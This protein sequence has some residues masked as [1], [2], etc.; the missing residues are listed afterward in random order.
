[1]NNGTANNTGNVVGVGNNR[2]VSADGIYVATATGTF[3][4]SMISLS[5]G[6]V[7]VKADSI[8]EYE[9]VL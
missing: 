1:V 7:V 4:V 9:E 6:G 2:I 8:L 3:N 5:A